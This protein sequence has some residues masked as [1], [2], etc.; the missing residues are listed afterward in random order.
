MKFYNY[1]RDGI[2]RRISQ[3][4][5]GTCDFGTR[6][7]EDE[8]F[9]MMDYY[10]GQGGNLIDTAHSYAEWL[11]NGAQASEKTIGKWLRSCGVRDKVLISTKGGLGSTPEKQ[12]FPALGRDNLRKELDESLDVLGTDY[13]DFYFLHRDDR[14]MPAGEIMETLNEFISEGKILTA[15]VS[16]W[17]PDRIAEANLY[18]ERKGLAPI[19]A[20]QILWEI[21]GLT[22]E[23]WGDPTMAAMNRDAMDFYLREEMLVLAF[24]PQTKGFFSKYI[25]QGEGALSDRL[26]ERIL[27]P[28]NRERAEKIRALSEETGIAPAALVLSCITDC[29]LRGIAI[30][31]SS[32]LEQLRESMSGQEFVM[33][34]EIRE[35]IAAV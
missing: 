13:V 25:A 2:S 34:P 15:G 32:K 26:K 8:A 20:S 28:E 12:H 5:L 24:S 33:D 23:G 30:V 27:T 31:G 4:A 6:I 7:P 16:N 21:T 22:P 10:V 19:R 14:S 1:N 17:E 9:K 3:L 35:R 18:A 11:P 29:P